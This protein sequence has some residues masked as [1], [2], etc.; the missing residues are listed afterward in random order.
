[1]L[2]LSRPLSSGET[3]RPAESSTTMWVESSERA[4]AP[5]R[6][7]PAATCGGVVDAGARPA[8]GRRRQRLGARAVKR[9][10]AK[11]RRSPRSPSRERARR[12]TQLA[13]RSWRS[14]LAARQRSVARAA[15]RRSAGSATHSSRAWSMRA[16]ALGARRRAGRRS[17]TA[18]ASRSWSRRGVG[19]ERV[20][21]V[22][23]RRRRA[24]RASPRRPPAAPPT[25]ASK[26][27][28]PRAARRALSAV[29]RVVARAG[30]SRRPGSA[31]RSSPARPRPASGT[32]RVRLQGTGTTCS[33]PSGA[34][35]EHGAVE[36]EAERHVAAASAG[37]ARRRSTWPPR[38]RGRRC[39][40]PRARTSSTRRTPGTTRADAAPRRGLGRRRPSSPAGR[41]APPA[42]SRVSAS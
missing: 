32:A 8:R 4:S 35:V 42:A 17:R 13:R 14:P 34:A 10:P 7:S 1:M 19:V 41:T 12:A 15:S 5:A 22:Q 39:T 23:Q 36:V 40:A 3:K 31:R 6:S 24:H 2:T 26:L 11:R 29:E 25:Q 27:G 30:S 38:P 9:P 21:L 28:R 37:S 16:G 20:A 18:S 33:R